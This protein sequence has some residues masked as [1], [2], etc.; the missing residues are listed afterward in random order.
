MPRARNSTARWYYD[1]AA[2]GRVTA[3]DAQ[4]IMKI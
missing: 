1:N 4:K 3:D 2:G